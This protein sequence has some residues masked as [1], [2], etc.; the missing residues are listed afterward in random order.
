MHFVVTRFLFILIFVVIP[1][2]SIRA[3]DR[4]GSEISLVGILVISQMIGFIAGNVLSGYLGDRHGVRLPMIAGR[5]ILILA[6][7]LVLAATTKWLFMVVFFCLGFGLSTGQVGDMT[8]V[9]DFAPP[10]RRK[11]FFAVM[12]VLMVPGLLLAALISAILQ[13]VPG[14]FHL[15]CAVSA[16]GMGASLFS[17]LRLRDPRQHGHSLS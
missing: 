9:I 6:I 14:S 7:G 13:Y 1:F 4:T 3:I 11:F 15:A 8:M 17:L 12:S 2:L 10:Y 16:I 5:L